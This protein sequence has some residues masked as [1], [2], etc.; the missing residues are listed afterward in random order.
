[1]P[2]IS[3]MYMRIVMPTLCIDRV[4]VKRKKGN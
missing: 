1:M 4:T 2:W 3:N